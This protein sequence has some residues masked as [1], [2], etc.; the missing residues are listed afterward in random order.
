MKY[1]AVLKSGYE[2]EIETDLN[3]KNFFWNK[4]NIARDTAIPF[5][6]SK[7][8]VILLDEIAVVKE[9]NERSGFTPFDY[10]RF[11]NNVTPP[12]IR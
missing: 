3:F 10:R 2:Q 9:Y 11:P 4:M 1:I 5:E 6:D 8:V 12:P 7:G